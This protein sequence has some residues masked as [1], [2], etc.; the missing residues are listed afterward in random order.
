MNAQT[1]AILKTTT[2]E[3]FLPS[4]MVYRVFDHDQ[5]V[6]RLSKLRCMPFD[7]STNRWTWNYEAE[8][9]K[10]GFPAAYEN[11][12]PERRPL[13][14]ASCYLIAPDTLHVYL[15]STLR[16]RKFM[17]FFDRRIPRA[18][19]KAEFLDQYNLLTILDSRKPPARPITPEDYFLDASK[20]AVFDFERETSDPAKAR[21]LP[22]RVMNE[23]LQ[24]LKRVRLDAFYED[25]DG[26]DH[27]LQAG[28]LREIL[29]MKQH[30]SDKPIRPYEV[31]LEAI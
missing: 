24:P 13:L 1:S 12:P 25:K 20:I 8:A 16:L 22:S 2:D 28:R 5:L 18:C 29:A 27:M 19:S 14:L 7:P 10:C 26:E 23:E 30:Q 9:K 31:F 6:K 17:V 11:I 4:R 21:E 3:L 15:R